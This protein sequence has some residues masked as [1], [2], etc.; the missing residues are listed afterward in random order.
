MIPQIYILDIV[1]PIVT[2][3]QEWAKVEYVGV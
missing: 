2:G 3:I 1:M